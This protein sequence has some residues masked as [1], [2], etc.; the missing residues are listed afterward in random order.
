MCQLP[1]L[2]TDTKRNFVCHIIEWPLKSTKYDRVECAGFGRKFINFRNV[3]HSATDKAIKQQT[4]E[5]GHKRNII[6][7][8]C[9][10]H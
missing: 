1:V 9:H 5:Y 8:A 4:C 7:V 10:L 6:S 2:R 3:S